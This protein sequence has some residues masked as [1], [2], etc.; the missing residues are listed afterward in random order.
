MSCVSATEAHILKI[1]GGL[2]EKLGPLLWPLGHLLHVFPA[3]WYE[4]NVASNFK[5][6]LIQLKVSKN[7]G[8]SVLPPM[9]LDSD[10]DQCCSESV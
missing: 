4:K 7:H 5:T 8:F 2:G 1:S 10:R 9:F 6:Y 3:L